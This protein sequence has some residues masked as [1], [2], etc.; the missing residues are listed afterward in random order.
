MQNR[1]RYLLTD[2]PFQ[3]RAIYVEHSGRRV[4]GKDRQ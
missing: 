3:R 4:T 1:L 2:W